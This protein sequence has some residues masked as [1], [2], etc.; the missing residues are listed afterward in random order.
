MSIHPYEADLPSDF[1]WA[2]EEL[3]FL[4]VD[5]LWDEEILFFEE[6]REKAWKKMNKECKDWTYLVNDIGV[7]EYS[8]K[9]RAFTVVFDHEEFEK[10]FGEWGQM[11]LLGEDSR[12]D[13]LREGWWDL[14]QMVEGMVRGLFPKEVAIRWSPREWKCRLMPVRF[15]FDGRP[16]SYGWDEKKVV[17]DPYE[18]LHVLDK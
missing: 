18:M 10:R 12:L 13:G 1:S 2:R 7:V 15:L 14:R 9:A 17:Y 16:G 11:R 6:I 8:S 5:A 4:D 3:D